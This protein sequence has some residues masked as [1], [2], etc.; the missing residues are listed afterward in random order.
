MDNRTLA[1]ML[2]LV[3]LLTAGLA[4]AQV[5]YLPLATG[6]T[7]NY[8]TDAGLYETRVITGQT[9]VFDQDAWVMEYPGS[10]W[11]DVLDQY[12][13]VADNGDVLFHG[14]WREDWGRV[15]DPPLLVVDAPLELGQA[16]STTV[17]SYALPDLEYLS[18]FTIFYEVSEAG[19]YDVPAG[20]FEAFGVGTVEPPVVEKDGR[21]YSVYGE[22]MVPGYRTT[23]DWWSLGVGLVQYVHV[24]FLQLESYQIGT[25]AV[26]DHTWSGVKSLFE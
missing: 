12:W 21:R 11:N 22:L 14:Y 7:W 10:P 17:D 18:T 13:S 24:E 8:I 25:V 6:N 3:L 15:Y 19:T 4:S 26:Q 2:T 1:R 9:T 20:S 5:D 16:W 23:S